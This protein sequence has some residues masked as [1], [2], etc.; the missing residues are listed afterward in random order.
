[1]SPEPTSQKN[2]LL[3]AAIKVDIEKIKEALAATPPPAADWLSIA[4]YNLADNAKENHLLAIKL[5]LDHDA[6]IRQ[7]LVGRACRHKNIELFQLMYDYGWG[8]YE[9]NA[10]FSKPRNLLLSVVRSVKALQWLLDHGL[11]PNLPAQRGPI[12]GEGP[13]RYIGPLT[14]LS[15]AAKESHRDADKAVEAMELLVSRGAVVDYNVLSD[16]IHIW[17]GTSV[18]FQGEFLR[19][20]LQHGSGF[21]INTQPVGRYPLLHSS[22]MSRRQHLVAWLLENGADTSTRVRMQSSGRWMNALELAEAVGHEPIL[23]QVRASVLLASFGRGAVAAE[24]AT[25]EFQWR[26]RWCRADAINQQL[27]AETP[28]S[29]PYGYMSSFEKKKHQEVDTDEAASEIERGW[30]L[31]LGVAASMFMSHGYLG[32]L[33]WEM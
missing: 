23:E 28:N 12:P 15:A 3:A 30:T 18:S 13:R 22:I 21:D 10:V 27:N 2:L 29:T 7:E 4:A 14:P 6:S 20:I 25:A 17:R 11:D 33:F 5:I 31:W 8:E 24:A 1:M 26:I 9:I 32:L 16:A 19:W